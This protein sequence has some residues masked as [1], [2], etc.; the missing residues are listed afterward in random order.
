MALL[1][2]EHAELGDR[3]VT[4][5]DDAL[6]QPQEPARQLTHGRGVEEVRTVPDAT[7]QPG[8]SAVGRLPLG[9][10]E[11]EIGS[12]HLGRRT[13]GSDLQ[14][15]QQAAQRLQGLT[16][17]VVQ[18]E[19]DLEE[20]VVGEGAG[21]VEVFDEAL[22][23]EVLVGVGVEAGGADAVEEFA[24]GG[25]A[26][27]VGAQDEG[28]DEEADKVVGRLV[29]AAGDGS[30]DRDVGSRAEAGEKRGHGGLEDH[31]QAGAVPLRQ[32]GQ[33][34][35]ELGRHCELRT[36]TRLGGN[37]GPCPSHGQRHLVR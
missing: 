17:G 14:T 21:G 34:L 3:K 11:R 25:P 13:L 12:R 7:A 8:R 5:L 24:E 16:L 32:R 28:V 9:Q 31:E 30:T 6:K 1:G 26:A 2:A 35:V 10:L 20:G 29:R 37:G 36:S 19:H 23:G 22:E 4:V 15:V 33:L 27:G 18:D